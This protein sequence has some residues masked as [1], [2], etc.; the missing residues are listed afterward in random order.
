MR[1][2]PHLELKK[3]PNGLGVIVQRDATPSGQD[4]ITFGGPSQQYFFPY[5][6]IQFMTLTRNAEKGSYVLHI[7][8]VTDK[9]NLETSRDI[10]A[11]FAE[12]CMLYH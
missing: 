2:P 9:I 5:K 4:S 7:R 12:I 8:T 10:E 11:D 1:M 6:V 3:Y